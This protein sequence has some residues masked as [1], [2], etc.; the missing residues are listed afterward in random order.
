MDLRFAFLQILDDLLSVPL[1]DE[2]SGEH[3]SE[4][5]ALFDDGLHNQ[6]VVVFFDSLDVHEFKRVD[7]ADNLFSFFFMH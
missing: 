3:G 1:G 5:T 2:A 4:G 6:P 7:L